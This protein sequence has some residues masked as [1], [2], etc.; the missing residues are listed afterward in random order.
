M[1]ITGLILGGL[2]ASVILLIGCFLLWAPGCEDTIC[3]I[4][5]SPDRSHKVI[6]YTR[7]CGATTGFGTHIALAQSDEDIDDG[8]TIF[9]ADDDHGKAEGHP[10]YY[11]LI[12][13]SAKWID[14]DSLEL[15]YDKN[16]RLFTDKD[17]AR[18][19]TIIHRK[20]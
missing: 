15:S 2:V 17:A 6:L 19:I 8:T 12:D 3:E 20:R 18:G 4:L 13:I 5:Y 10:G 7:N 1:K 11:E 14:D 16:A 9:V